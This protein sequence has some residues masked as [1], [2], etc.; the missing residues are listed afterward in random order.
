[1]PAIEEQRR[2]P[3]LVEVATPEGLEPVAQL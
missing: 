3:D 1:V 2:E